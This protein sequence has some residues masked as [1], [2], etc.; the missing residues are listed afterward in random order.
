MSARIDIRRGARLQSLR[1]AARRSVACIALVAASGPALP[2]EADIEQVRAATKRLVGLLVEQGV[3]TKEKADALL[4]DLVPPPAP[5]TAAAA[6]RGAASAPG[7][8]RVPYVPEFVRKEIKEEVRAE[9][10]AQAAREGWAGPGAVPAWTRGIEWDGDMRFRVQADRFADGNAPAIDVAATNRNRS[11]TLL[12]TTEDRERLRVRARAGLTATLDENWGAGIRLATGSATDPVSTNQ[13]LGTY[14]TRYTVTFDRAYARFHLD[15]V[16]SVVAGRFGNPWYGTDLV[17]ANDLTFDGIAAQWTPR[18]G[19]RARGFLT[20]GI[21]PIQE[22]ELS[23]S[24]KWLF[25]IQAGA[26]VPGTAQGVGGRAGLAYYHYKNIVGKTSP[27]GS[28]VNEFTAPAFAQKG[29]TYYNIS[30][31]PTRPLLGLASDYHLVN[32]TGQADFPGP[33]GRR[34]WVI[35]D[36]VRNIGFNRTEVSQRVGADVEPRVNGYALR[37]GFGHPEVR[38]RHDWQVF[39]GYKRVERD[40]VLDAFTDSDFHL[41]GTDARGY[42]LGGSYGLG[43][44]AAASLRIFSADAINGPPLSIDVFQLDLNLRF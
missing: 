5:A 33:G 25:A 32:L 38:A 34:I 43:R 18:L 20:L 41:G 13:T 1:S 14:N 37:V 7:T 15:D 12:N 35:G 19:S 39:M 36:F 6:P 44:N 27:A 31:D 21:L 28:S 17:W 3:I 9:I 24:D 16:G 11:L 2:A 29:N 10:A 8:V 30:S 42:M 23:S 4:R 40:A 22:V 26:E